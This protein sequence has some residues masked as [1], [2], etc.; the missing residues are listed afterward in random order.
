MDQVR[1]GCS[2]IYALGEHYNGEV[3]EDANFLGDY[4]PGNGNGWR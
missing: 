1:V 2:G 3:L 4:W